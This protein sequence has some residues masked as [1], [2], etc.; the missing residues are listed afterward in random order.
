MLSKTSL[1]VVLAW[2]VHLLTASGGLWGFLTILA[3]FDHNWP[4]AFIWIIIA[5]FVDSVDGTLARWLEVKKF[6]SRIDGGL[7]DNLIDYLNFVIVPALILIEAPRLLPEGYQLVT[8]GLII[9]TSAYQFSQ[10][11]AK[12]EDHFFTGFPSYWNVL[13]IYL[14]VMRLNVWVNLVVLV[15]FNIL[16][17]VPIKYLYPSRNTKL[18]HLTLLLSY[19]Y[20]GLGVWGLLRY[21]DVPAWMIWLSFVYILYYLVLSLWSQGNKVPSS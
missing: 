5:M 4:L 19:L 18:R 13:V 12:T 8:A 6:A 3:I 11:D 16:V 17:F 10:V 1:R 14:M 15:A 2:G 20:G 9:I 7:L 21:P